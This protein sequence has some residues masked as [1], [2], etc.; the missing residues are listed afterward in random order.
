VI[1]DAMEVYYLNRWWVGIHLMVSYWFLQEPI[2]FGSTFK[3]Y[4]QK[5][6]YVNYGLSIFSKPTIWVQQAQLL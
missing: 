1:N 6:K 3:E 2:I 5:L 4:F